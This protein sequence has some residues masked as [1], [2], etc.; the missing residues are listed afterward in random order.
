MTDQAMTLPETSPAAGLLP[1]SMGRMTLTEWAQMPITW[2]G[3]L[4]TDVV[5]A[6]G[7]LQAQIGAALPAPGQSLP[8]TGGHILWAGMG[9]ALIMGAALSSVAGAS[10]VD[11]SDAWC[12]LRLSGPDA[13]AIM[14]RLCPLDLGFDQF[15]EGVV[16]RSLIGHMNGIIWRDGADSLTV[17][18]YRSF[19]QTLVHELTHAMRAYAARLALA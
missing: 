17:M 4:S 1:Q 14:A 11:Q 6:S 5:A 13:P 3:L 12:A 8:C 18:V 19:A 7:D 10:V 16:A 2:V 15:E 9:Q